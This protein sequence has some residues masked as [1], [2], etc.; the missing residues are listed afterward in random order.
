V[1]VATTYSTLNLAMA[2]TVTVDSV[3]L[4]DWDDIG[5]TFT[6]GAAVT[7]AV[8]VVVSRPSSGL[9][10]SMLGVA[11]PRLRVV[12]WFRPSSGEGL[13][14]RSGGRPGPE[15]EGWTPG[16]RGWPRAAGGG[17]LTHPTSSVRQP[18]ILQPEGSG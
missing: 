10:M 4:G 12:L 15:V 8:S 11:P 9:I 18:T 13:G 3:V 5:K 1:A 16:R 17:A 14:R 6:P 2:G 7:D